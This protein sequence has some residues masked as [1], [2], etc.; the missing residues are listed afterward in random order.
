MQPL[1]PI[2]IKYLQILNSL[3]NSIIAKKDNKMTINQIQIQLNGMNISYA[4]K[5]SGVGYWA[6]WRIYKGV[7]QKPSHANIEKISKWLESAKN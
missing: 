7:T 4:A 5:Q 1:L 3:Y 2:S 6:L